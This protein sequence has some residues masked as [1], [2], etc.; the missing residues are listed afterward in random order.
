METTGS[1]AKVVLN[2]DRETI[3]ANGEDVVRAMLKDGRLIR[4]VV[5]ISRFPKDRIIELAQ[6][7]NCEDALLVEDQ[8]EKQEELLYGR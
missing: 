2:P 4:D 7:L 8:E 5:R 1:A 3:D 6:E